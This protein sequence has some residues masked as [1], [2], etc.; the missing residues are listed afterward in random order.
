MFYN[1]REMQVDETEK[2]IEAR[3]RTNI[4]MAV[5]VV[6][7]LYKKE[8]RKTS[9]ATGIKTLELLYLVR[10]KEYYFIYLEMFLFVS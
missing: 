2:W 8:F 3:D 6:T 1:K 5:F 9:Y 7:I 4:R 10:C